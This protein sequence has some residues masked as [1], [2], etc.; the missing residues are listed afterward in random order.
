MLRSSRCGDDQTLADDLRWRQVKN[1]QCPSESWAAHLS[2]IPLSTRVCAR[3]WVD[4]CIHSGLMC[5]IPR[6]YEHL[7]LIIQ[8]YRW[9]CRAMHTYPIHIHIYMNTHRD[10]ALIHTYAEI[11]THNPLN[12]FSR[13][14]LNSSAIW[15]YIDPGMFKRGRGWVGETH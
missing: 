9:L 3:V 14:C 5:T 4:H 1:W 15:P 6:S 8:L 11:S 12:R 10:I 7:I 13:A 2:T